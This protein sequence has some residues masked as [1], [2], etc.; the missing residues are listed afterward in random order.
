LLQRRQCEEEK[1]EDIHTVKIIKL[2]L[3]SLKIIFEDKIFINLPEIQF[4]SL[5]LE[6]FLIGQN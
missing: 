2:F 1:V 4:Q 5:A 3:D 6:F